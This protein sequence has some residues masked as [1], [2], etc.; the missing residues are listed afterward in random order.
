MLRI[1]I[2]D[3]VGDTCICSAVN[4]FFDRHCVFQWAIFL[5][6]MCA[7][8][9]P[10]TLTMCITVEAFFVGYVCYSKSLYNHLC[11]LQLA[12]FL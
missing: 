5:L 10:F 12:P 1:T 7:K 2:Y 11:V 4:T 9:K 6:I 8:V 3:S